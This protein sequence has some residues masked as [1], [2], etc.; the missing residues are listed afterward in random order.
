[1]FGRDFWGALER[2][3]KGRRLSLSLGAS[4]SDSDAGLEVWLPVT[5]TPRGLILH[6]HGGGNDARLGPW[7]LVEAALAEG[8]GCA[9]FHH[10][11]HGQGGTSRFSR[12]TALERVTRIRDHLLVTFPKTPLFA[13]GQSLGAA[14]LLDLLLTENEQDSGPSRFE[15]AIVVSPPH[16]LRVLPESLLEARLLLQPLAWRL[17]WELGLAE[18]FP[19]AG[20]IRRERFPVRVDR[21]IYRRDLQGRAPE[22][23][24]WPLEQAVDE[25]RLLPR[26]AA[27]SPERAVRLPPIQILHGARDRVIR[28]DQGR[29]VAQAL[30][31]VGAR[32]Q[33]RELAAEGHF[34]ILL[35]RRVVHELLQGV[36][37]HRFNR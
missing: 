20:P 9:L 7:R 5:G 2:E 31:G 33:Y 10:T 12:Q 1:M 27:L 24:V 28:V 23:P 4:D 17:A 30:E 37:G 19:A 11:G 18:V 22:D 15:G 35:D 26:I 32:V 29:A 34:D 21:E 25:M 36:P 6:F 16:T 13:L 8:F 3:G 14:I